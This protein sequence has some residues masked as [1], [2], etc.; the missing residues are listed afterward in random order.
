MNISEVNARSLL[1]TCSLRNQYQEISLILILFDSQ[2][3]YILNLK[4]IQ[5]R[6][7]PCLSLNLFMKESFRLPYYSYNISFCHFT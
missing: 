4:I 3:N 7:T 1:N 2:N 6:S 5:M